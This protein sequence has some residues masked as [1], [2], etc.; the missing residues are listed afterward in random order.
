MLG[1]LWASMQQDAN[2]S[3]LLPGHVKQTLAQ[4]GTVL[5]LIGAM[6][7]TVMARPSP[8]LA[9]STSQ[10]SI[11]HYVNFT[12]TA[13]T[14]TAL[15]DWA[16]A[17]AAREDP[18]G[19]NNQCAPNYYSKD[20]VTVLDFG[21]PWPSSGNYGARNWT[22]TWYDF[23]TIANLAY[24]YALDFY[25]NSGACSHVSVVI[26][27]NNSNECGGYSQTSCIY[28]EGYYL[29]WAVFAAENDIKSYTGGGDDL[30]YQVTTEGGDDIEDDGTSS[31]DPYYVTVN[32]LNGYNAF[33]NIKGYIKSN[34]F[35]YGYTNYPCGPYNASQHCGTPQYPY[36]YTWDYGELYN[37]VWGIGL[38]V[39][40][41]EAYNPAWG[42]DWKPVYNNT[43][44]NCS[45]CVGGSSGKIGFWGV[46]SSSG[47]ND[48]ANEFGSF[49]SYV[50]VNPI[51]DYDTCVPNLSGNI[52]PQ[53]PCY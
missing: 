9:L 1:K 31:W 44:N 19:D 29:A 15:K 6:I 25:N 3:S 53:S 20:L 14:E 45:D 48:P 11:S 34:L 41:P 36:Y 16:I 47:W 5:A 49:Y 17:D 35:D 13:Q 10:H 24:D 21:Q 33:P 18:P 50:G 22:Y 2:D 28:N 39:P 7:F 30:Q 23:G 27:M 38:D 51:L 32:F 37:V 52:F 26:G 40:L 46:E 42:G 43:P 8:A 12:T 4:A